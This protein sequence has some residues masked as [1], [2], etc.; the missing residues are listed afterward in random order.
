MSRLVWVMV[1][2]PIE[3]VELHDCKIIKDYDVTEAWG[4]VETHTTYDIDWGTATFHGYEV[5]LDVGD[6]DEVA[7]NYIDQMEG[8]ND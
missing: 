5:D 7:N 2:V 3:E 4:R 8:I 1:R 6:M